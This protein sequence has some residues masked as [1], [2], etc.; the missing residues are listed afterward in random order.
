MKNVLLALVLLF[1][2]T[3]AWAGDEA[4]EVEPVVEQMVVE[5]IEQEI[6]ETPEIDAEIS[7]EAETLPLDFDFLKTEAAVCPFGAPRCRS[8]SMC[9]NYCG[10]P[11]FGACINYCCA[12]SG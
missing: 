4:V 5:N 3:A 6:V 8:N 2:A 10:A 11:G 9:D 7:S 12:C 1:V